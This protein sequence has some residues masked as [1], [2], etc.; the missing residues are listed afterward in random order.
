MMIII[1]IQVTLTFLIPFIFQNGKL[2]D[3]AKVPSKRSLNSST[4]KHIVLEHKAGSDAVPGGTIP[5]LYGLIK[6]ALNSGMSTST[7][8]NTKDST[9]KY[10]TEAASKDNESNKREE[11][12]L[13]NEW[14]DSIVNVEVLLGLKKPKNSYEALAVRREL[15]SEAPDWCN[16]SYTTRMRLQP[17]TATGIRPKS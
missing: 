10:Q 11:S 6:R 15:G 7:E 1:I 13:L 14:N 4:P 9:K 17:M 16:D 5:D 12:H 3:S 8:S 2:K